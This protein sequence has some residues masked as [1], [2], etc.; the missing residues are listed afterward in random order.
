MRGHLIKC[1]GCGMWKRWPHVDGQISFTFSRD[2]IEL[3]Q[4]KCDKCCFHN[5]LFPVT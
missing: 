5:S 3:Y 4:W 1:D 2:L